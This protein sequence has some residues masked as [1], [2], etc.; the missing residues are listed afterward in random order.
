MRGE[1][2]CRSC[3]RAARSGPSPRAWG[4]PPRHP[5]TGAVARTIP[6][7][8]GS[9]RRQWQGAQNSPD[10]PHVRGEH[11]RSSARASVVSGP[12]PRA[13]GAPRNWSRERFPHRTIPTCVGSTQQIV[14]RQWLPS[15]HPH[16]RGEHAAI[17][18]LISRLVGPSPRAWGAPS[19]RRSSG[20][21]GRTIPTCVG[22]T[23]PLGTW[24]SLPADHPHV[25]GEHILSHRREPAG[26]GPSPRAWGAQKLTCDFS[27][28]YLAV[29]NLAGGL[30]QCS[31]PR[32]T[33]P[34]T[35]RCSSLPTESR[36]HRP[37]RPGPV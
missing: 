14:P 5:L 2:S 15:D 23:P 27:R 9:T 25:R 37:G 8:V 33:F 7:C 10:H 32:P 18:N 16:V 24:Q 30:S 36:K 4:A 3:R 11:R 29:I 13:W 31:H 22:S 26:L 20:S 19:P 34:E 6:T 12:S 1:H 35:H 21:P 28:R 17:G